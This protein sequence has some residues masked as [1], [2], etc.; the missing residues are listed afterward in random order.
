MRL[1]LASYQILWLTLEQTWEAPSDDWKEW[2]ERYQNRPAVT[3]TEYAVE[4]LNFIRGTLVI[5]PLDF[6]KDE[7]KI[8][9]FGDLL[10]NPSLAVTKEGIAQWL[11]G[12]LFE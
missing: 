3:N 12:S 7:Q 9:T 1:T 2:N 6:L 11:N 5:H 10:S 8:K 4:R